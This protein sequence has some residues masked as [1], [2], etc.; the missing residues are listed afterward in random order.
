MIYWISVQPTQLGSKLRRFSSGFSNKTIIPQRPSVTIL[1]SKD[2]ELNC[3][4]FVF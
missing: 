4:S 1:V 2:A 3:A